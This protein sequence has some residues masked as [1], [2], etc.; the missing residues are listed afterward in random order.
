MITKYDGC[1]I[2]EDHPVNTTR[3]GLF[4]EA[5]RKV[6]RHDPGM[7]TYVGDFRILSHESILEKK[8][9]SK[10]FVASLGRVGGR[11]AYP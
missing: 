3:G 5:C 9:R 10:P 1:P 11:I 8:E 7:W 4:D 6:W 2:P